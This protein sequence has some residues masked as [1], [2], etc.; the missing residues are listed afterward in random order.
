M[1]VGSRRGRTLQPPPPTRLRPSRLLERGSDWGG[2]EGEVA[3]R[4]ALGGGWPKPAHARGRRPPR[5]P[6][7]PLPWPR[8]APSP[9]APQSAPRGSVG[10]WRRR[11]RE[12]AAAARGTAR[13]GGSGAARGHGCRPGLRAGG[14]GRR[15]A[16]PA[17]PAPAWAVR[18]GRARARARAGGSAGRGQG[19]GPGP[20]RRFAPRGVAFAGGRALP[21]PPRLAQPGPARGPLRRPRQPGRSLGVASG[22]G[23]EVAGWGCVR[24]TSGVWGVYICVCHCGVWGCIYVLARVCDPIYA[25]VCVCV[26]TRIIHLC[27]SCAR[28]QHTALG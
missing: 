10:Q 27:V 16:G 5:A 6:S 14:R 19:P 23:D 4:V 24:V 1:A 21:R 3:R 17:S 13:R 9:P 25:R 2:G 20:R 22:R 12:A 11:G 15:P 7:P 18:H 26:S 28:P 8:P